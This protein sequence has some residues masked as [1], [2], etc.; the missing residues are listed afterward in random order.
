[1]SIIQVSN[2]EHFV[3][4]KD[5]GAILIF[6]EVNDKFF[7][8]SR[9]SGILKGYYVSPKK[10]PDL[11]VEKLIFSKIE[12]NYYPE[13]YT[14]FCIYTWKDDTYTLQSVLNCNG[15]LPID[16]EIYNS[17]FSEL[18]EDVKRDTL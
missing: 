12:R 15:G 14:A 6:L 3:G 1:M 10:Y 16:K 11:L 17:M 9:I 4:R 7:Y 5:I 18:N 8:K 13:G 2:T